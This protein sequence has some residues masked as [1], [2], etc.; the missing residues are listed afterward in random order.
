MSNEEQECQ[1]ELLA[2]QWGARLVSARESLSISLEQ[3]ATDLNLPADYIDSLERGSLDGLPSMVFARGYIRSYAKLL[4]LDNGDELVCEFE[5]LHGEG[6]CRGQIRPVSKVRQQVKM[7]DPVMKLSSW[8]FVLA[9][10]GVSVWWWQTQYGGSFDFTSADDSTSENAVELSNEPAVVLENGQA[11]LALPTL[12]DSPAGE[13]SADSSAPAEESEPQYLSSNEIK[14]LQQAIDKNDAAA[15]A[16]VSVPVAA[17]PVADLL[18]D[19][20]V[21]ADFVAECWV[22]IKD[23]DGKNLFNNLRGK[24]QSVNVTGKPPLSVL[25]GA[26]DA[27]GAF[28]YNGKSFDLT[29]YNRKNVVR[30]SLPVSE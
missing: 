13:T 14:K 26:A 25:I 19:I 20:T 11:Q 2:E 9:I 3:A 29:P 24:G 27:V 4:G 30:L 6:S 1:P 10:I 23:A 17:A 21:S 7:N 22:S 28:R 12:D 5:E 15:T 16:E 18:V 8:V